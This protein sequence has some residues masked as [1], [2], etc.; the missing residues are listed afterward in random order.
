MLLCVTRIAVT[1]ESEKKTLMKTQHLKSVITMALVLIAVSLF[2]QKVVEGVGPLSNK[3]QKGLM[4]KTIFDESGAIS[5]LYKIKGDKKKDEMFYELYSFDK[6]LKFLEGKSVTE[7]KVETKP[8]K[9]AKYLGAWVGGSSS[10]DAMSMKLKVFMKEVNQKWD[11][12]KQRYVNSKVISE[13]VIK[14]KTEAG[15]NYLG[16]AEYRNE[17][18]NNLVVLAY[19]ETGDKKNPKQYVLLN[20]DYD[21]GVKEKNIDVAGAY[22]MVFCQEISEEVAG[23]NVG[24]QDFVMVVAPKSGNG[25]PTQY[26]YLHYDINGTLKNKVAFKSPS[27]NLLINSVD[28]KN[29]EVFMSALSTKSKDA[30]E[31]VFRDY[32]SI[33]NPGGGPNQESLQL[34]KYNKAAAE[35]M[36]NLHLLKFSGDKLIFATTAAVSEFKAKKRFAEGEKSGKIYNG[37]KFTVQNF[38]VTPNNEFLVSGQITFWQMI[39][40]VSIKSYGDIIC[41][42]FD[43]Q[44]QIK[45]QYAVDKLYEDRAS[46]ISIMP[47]KFFITADGKSAYWEIMEFKMQKDFFGNYF[48]HYFPRIVKVDLTNDT[49]GK[50]TYPGNKKYY[51]YHGDGEITMYFDA[52]TATRTYVGIGLKDEEVWVSNVT[53][54]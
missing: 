29:G 53:F 36:D 2:G 44:G 30:Y 24:K 51:V 43:S 16:V 47:Q 9:T 19:Y 12:K 20:I 50:F 1:F 25:D 34:T 15:R 33:S 23:K 7:P 41:F 38:E 5:I 40:N 49:L 48:P 28:V 46:E 14:L 21:G 26:V 3:A 52:D 37:K 31:E 32:A 42:H 4:D 11:Y 39:N 13:E 17:E 18:N 6:D 35:E 54:N 8:D 27:P 22:S 10:F 45:A